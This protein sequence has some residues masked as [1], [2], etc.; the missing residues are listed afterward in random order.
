ML[1]DSLVLLEELVRKLAQAVDGEH[2]AL[3]VVVAA[4]G[5]EVLTQDL[6]DL[7]P[8]QPH[9]AVAPTAVVSTTLPGAVK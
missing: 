5:R 9:P 7:A 4:D 6:P 1:N 3:I 8:D 2:G